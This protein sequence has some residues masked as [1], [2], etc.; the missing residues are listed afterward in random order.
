[1]NHPNKNKKKDKTLIDIL[2]LFPKVE[3]RNERVRNFVNLC[4]RYLTWY[5]INTGQS[6]GDQNISGSKRT[7]THNEIMSIIG[8]LFLQI[9]AEKKFGG[10]TPDRK[11]VRNMIIAHADKYQ[12]K[13]Q[14]KIKKT[15]SL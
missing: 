14:N 15:A 6:V 2:Y 9:N 10:N 1:M 8:K 13:K 12:Y 5:K 4:Y 11:T 7:Q 3:G